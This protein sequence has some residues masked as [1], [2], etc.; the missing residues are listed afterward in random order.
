MSSHES[1]ER[2]G[3]PA[4]FT[5][6]DPKLSV[7]HYEFR[8]SLMVKCLRKTQTRLQQEDDAD[9]LAV[10]ERAEM[11]GRFGEVVFVIQDVQIRS[12]DLTPQGISVVSTDPSNLL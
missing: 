10:N 3:I 11:Y 5:I 4:G 9:K 6:I 2:G 8:I 7:F 1:M 12:Q